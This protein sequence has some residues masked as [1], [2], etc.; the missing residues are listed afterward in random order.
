M[1]IECKIGLWSVSGADVDRVI[2]EAKH[3][4]IQYYYDGE[5]DKLLNKG[6]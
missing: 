4:F 1:T 2:N 5:Y 3:Y 6:E